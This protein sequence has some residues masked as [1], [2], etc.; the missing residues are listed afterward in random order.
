[1]TSAQT[2]DFVHHEIDQW[3]AVVKA[4]NIKLQ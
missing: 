1:M 4:A 2:R 3:A